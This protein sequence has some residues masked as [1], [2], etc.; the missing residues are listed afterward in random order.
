MCR[1]P[2]TDYLISHTIY[3]GSAKNKNGELSI[4]PYLIS[5]AVWLKKL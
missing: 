5:K 1:A 3:F 4:N 2:D